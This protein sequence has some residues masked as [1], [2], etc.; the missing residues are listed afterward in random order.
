MPY[1]VWCEI[2]CGT[3]ADVITGVWTDRDVPRHVLKAEALHQKAVLDPDTGNW[4]CR[5]CES[6]SGLAY[7]MYRINPNED[8]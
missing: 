5:Y 8:G 1:P 7:P 2:V 3:C 4:T 6:E